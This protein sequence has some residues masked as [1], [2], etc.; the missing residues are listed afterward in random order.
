MCIVNKT[1]LSYGI[2]LTMDCEVKL[3]LYYFYLYALL[4]YGQVISYQLS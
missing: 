1:V 4:I 2:Y 3:I